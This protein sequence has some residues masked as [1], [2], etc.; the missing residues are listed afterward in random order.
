MRSRFAEDCLHGTFQEGVRQYAMLGAGLDTVAY[1][2][3][4]WANGPSD[5]RGRSSGNAAM[6][7]QAPGGGR[8][9][10]AG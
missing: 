8:Y 3:P 1:R 4:P 2:Q 10:R 7:A 6:E 5:L 9:H